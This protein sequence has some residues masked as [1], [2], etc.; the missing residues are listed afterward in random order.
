MVFIIAT[1]KQTVSPSICEQTQTT[2][3]QNKSKYW[4][5]TT[6]PPVSL[7]LFQALFASPKEEW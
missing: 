5:A 1:E 3:Q 6:E 2:Q 7:G 4:H